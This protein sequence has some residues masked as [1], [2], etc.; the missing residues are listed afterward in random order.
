MGIQTEFLL[1]FLCG[2]ING[3]VKNFEYFEDGEDGE[4]KSARLEF[5]DDF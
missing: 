5:L 2:M 1:D 4:E 3:L